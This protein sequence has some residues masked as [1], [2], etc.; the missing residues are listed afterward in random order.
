M[1]LALGSLSILVFAAL[2]QAAPPEGAAGSRKASFQSPQES[3]APAAA[4]MSHDAHDGALVFSAPP[5]EAPEEANRL[6]HPI[7]EY[8]GRVTGKKVVYR[9]PGNWLTYQTEMQRGTYDIVFDGPHFTSW[10]ISH[11]RHNTLARL[12]EEH[13]F[14]VIVRKD[15]KEI[16]DVKQ[17]AGKRVCAMTP[18]N[19]GTLALLG[20]FDNPSRQPQIAATTGWDGIYFGVVAENKCAAGVVPVANLNKYDRHGNA[21]RVIYR[22]R[23]MPNQAFSAGPRVTR[24][25][26]VKITQAL[27]SDEGEAVTAALRAAYGIEKGFVAASK[28]EYAGLDVYLKDSWGYAGSR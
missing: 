25:D 15:D 5:R 28:S 26:Q 14:A 1:S 3:R 7:A 12:G 20:H 21:S 11:L 18:P 13:T 8:L 27:T 23:P 24:E 17:L 16:T 19:L 22:T 10:R 2:A 6:Y 4:A 9:A